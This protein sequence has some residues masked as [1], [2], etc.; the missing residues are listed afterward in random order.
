MDI[1]I[2]RFGASTEVEMLLRILFAAIVGGVIGLERRR[3]ARSSGIRTLA[4][5]AMGAGAFTFVSIFGFAGEEG[6]MH[7][8]GSADRYDNPLIAPTQ[9]RL[10][11][12]FL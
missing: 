8:W 6:Q 7:N 1:V 12:R 4:L 11:R 2:F 5:V 10:H 9:S 3:A